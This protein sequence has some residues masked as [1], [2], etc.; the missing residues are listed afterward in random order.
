MRCPTVCIDAKPHRRD[1]RLRLYIYLPLVPA[2]CHRR[3]FQV[4]PPCR[5]QSESSRLVVGHRV[6]VIGRKADVVRG[7]S[8]WSLEWPGWGLLCGRSSPLIGA[9]A[10]LRAKTV[11]PT[12]THNP[13]HIYDNNSIRP[14]GVL[15]DAFW[16]GYCRI[17]RT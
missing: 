5:G 15:F 16:T 14:L 4:W 17:Q 3:P 8:P 1:T 13:S 7:E 11:V 12:L 9:P 10:V 2:I 6:A